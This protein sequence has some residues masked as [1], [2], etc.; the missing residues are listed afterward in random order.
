MP[1]YTYRCKQCGREFK[2]FQHM[3]DDVLTECSVCGGEVLRL[4]SGGVGV[5]YK[6][7]GFY[8]N[9]YKKGIPLKPEKTVKDPDNNKADTI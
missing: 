6:G 7:A 8:V 1:T 9:D 5:I 3:T 4:L 2:Q